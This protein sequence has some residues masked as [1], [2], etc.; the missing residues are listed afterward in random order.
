MNAFTFRDDVISRYESF[1]RSFTRIH[2]PDIK[3]HVEAEY[4]RGRYWPEP[5]VQINPNY[6]TGSTIQQ[7]ADEGVVHQTTAAIFK[8]G[9]D[10]DHPKPVRLYKHQEQ[11]LAIS[12]NRDSY[13]VTTGTGSGKSLA[14][15]IP[16]ADQ[17]L[18]AKDA[19]PTPRTR[20]IVIYP[21]NALA[22]SQ[23]EELGKFLQDFPPEGKPLTVACYTG[24]EDNAERDA[25][26]ESPPDILLTNF[27]MLELILTRQEERDQQI[28]EKCRGLEFLVLDELH[29]YRGRQ[30]ADV[31]MLVRR[32]RQRLE[33]DQLVCIGTSAT[34]SNDGTADDRK[35]TVAA[36][37]SKLFGTHVSEAHV[38]G[39]TLERATEPSLDIEAVRSSLATRLQQPSGPWPTLDDFKRDPFAVWTELTL[40]LDL[41]GPEGPERARPLPLS[42]AVTL[43]LRDAGLLEDDRPMARKALEDF[44]IAAQ[45]V[46]TDAGRSLFAFKLHQFI[47]GPG[48]VLCTLEPEGTRQITLDAQRFAPGRRSEQ[49]LLFPTHFCRECGQEYHPVWETKD[50]TPPFSPRE[51]DDVGDDDQSRRFGFLAPVHPD[52]DYKGETSDLPD[53]WLDL[54]RTPAKVKQNYRNAVPSLERIDPQGCRGNSDEYW[55]IPGKFRFCL[56]CGHEHQ[57]HGRDI[58][59]LSG[60]SGEGRSSA[61][62]VL[63]LGILSRHFSEPL[64]EN[65]DFDPRKL[66][67]FSDNRQDAALQ[68]GHFNDFL[69]LLLMRSGLLAA[70]AKSGGELQIGDL[71]H[72]IFQ[73][74]GFDRDDH[75]HSAEYLQDPD[76]YGRQKEDADKAARFVLSYRAIHDLR[77]GW[78]FNNPNLQQLD[79]LTVQYPDLGAF[80][81]DNKRFSKSSRSDDLT[82]E[83][84]AA[85]ETLSSL[86]PKS[87]ERLATLIFEAMLR[88]LCIR[89]DFLDT[90]SQEKMQ[91]MIAGRLTERWGIGTDEKLVTSKSL[92]LDKRPDTRGQRKRDDLVGGGPRSRLIRQIRYANDWDDDPVASRF[93][94]FSGA[95][96]VEIVRAFLEAAS[97]AFTSKRKIGPSCD[98]WLLDDTALLW[99]LNDSPKE[100][101]SS[102]NIFFRDLYQSTAAMLGDEDR[103]MFQFEACEHTAQVEPER[104]KILEARFRMSARD[105]EWWKQE[106]GQPGPITRLPIL[107]CSPT[108]ELGVDISALNTVYMRNVPPTPANYAQR[109]GRAGRSG[110]AALAITYCAAMS[111]HDQWFYHN[112]SQMVHGVVK[113]PTLDL[114]NRPLIESHLH[115]VW[116]ASVNHKI[117]TSIAPLLDLD[118]EHKPL[119][120]ELQEA[121]NEPTVAERAL[122]A[123]R[124]VLDQVEDEGTLPENFAETIV[125]RC[126]ERFSAAFD[127][128]RALYDATQDQMAK[129]DKLNRSHATAPRDRE[130]A[131]RRY[132][133]AS[134]QLRHLL[135]TGG[136]QNNDFYTFRY[137]ASQGF[138]P[139]YNFPRLP[140]M[141]WIPATKGRKGAKDQEGN[142]VSRPRFLALS[143]FG[144]R[145]LI[146]HQGRMFRVARAKLGIT[147]ADQVTS[148]SRLATLN[149]LV[150]ESCGYGHLGKPEDP[151]PKQNVCDYCGSGFTPESRI[152]ELYRI[153][154]VETIP[155]QRIS[156]N[157]EER[158]RQG[159][160][161]ITTFRFLPGPGGVPEK[162]DASV[163]HD[164]AEIATITYSP[165]ASIW[166]INRG[167]RRRKNKN[168]L[169]FNINPID[170]RWSKNE[171]SEED[172]GD[173]DDRDEL[174][175]VPAQRIVPFVEDHRN[176]LILTP[177]GDFSAVTMA[178]LQAALKRGV[179][180][181]FE[182][183]SSE[184]AVE[185]L[186]TNQDRRS[187]LF[188]ESAEGGAGV[189]KRLVKDRASLR[190][191]ARTALDLMHYELPASED[192]APSG[193]TERMND[194][195]GKPICEAGCYQ[196][197]LSYFNQPDHE[198]IDR[199]NEDAVTFLCQLATAN[200]DPPRPG[201]VTDPSDPASG[202]ES[203]LDTLSSLGLQHPEETNVPIDGGE[204]TAD[205]LYRSARALVFLTPP[206]GG[207][208]AYATDR[209]FTVIEFPTDSSEWPSVFAR[210][211]DIFG[212]TPASE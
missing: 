9:K 157:E 147:A 15:F 58:N 51:I 180:Q 169:G 62:T 113:P 151:D 183:E 103:T 166:R 176:L 109:S 202:L 100:D 200:I 24:Q 119:T 197:V 144:P 133:D 101:G 53:G 78:R 158:Q 68:A 21:M 72:A 27:M 210:F 49:V 36:V 34:M 184:L 181:V 52:Q 57:A 187:L 86:T 118:E 7:L 128:W 67:G 196:C 136:G 44:L 129:A 4:D 171:N 94:Q 208:A 155:V 22:N 185:S 6:K 13:V 93:N 77:K 98:G 43:L 63:T 194:R 74:L 46:E 182:I 85:W 97:P 33:A 8:V 107:Y 73:A 173:N 70:L 20:A 37:A 154:T 71:G 203:W 120:D 40:G 92:I 132:T 137:L 110:Q 168:Q 124:G 139:G 99:K 174:K 84:E 17:I 152:N 80:C 29:T 56:K 126:P 193:L 28:I 3:G 76:L 82:P 159:F 79:L 16:M 190:L 115:A 38:V 170:G 105:K 59:R 104:R 14:F 121:I 18:R 95:E 1:S 189:L 123:I 153:E 54:N 177:P 145:S 198:I 96:L 135:R 150:C 130:N 112:A 32:L 141:A 64:D 178:T 156:V 91:P 10:S 209:G 55:F 122:A 199:R 88:D 42:E 50:G 31:A 175:K 81:S 69:F 186:P 138:L 212:T 131:K 211:P 188:Y 23:M 75:L 87:R 41:S 60:L 205:A 5:M 90:V 19:D 61:T 30:G 162:S 134:N 83:K 11:A 191:A 25:I 114:T 117:E 207:T 195:T 125:R 47:S 65:A 161:I 204:A 12:R 206:S 140:L 201:S 2:A 143:E 148:D 45:E 111:P 39:E 48:K 163:T 127:R 89:S 160:D 116:L 26:L 192:L 164:G 106:S 165:A 108:M 66:L 179:E 146:Y 172:D 142:M 102:A 167:W 149:A 35:Q